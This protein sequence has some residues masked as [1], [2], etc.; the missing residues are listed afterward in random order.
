MTTFSYRGVTATGATVKGVVEAD[1]PKQ[2]RS[3]LLSD[4]IIVEYLAPTRVEQSHLLRR[5]LAVRERAGIFHGL[6]ELMKAGLAAGDAL[7]SLRSTIAGGRTRLRLELALDGIREGKGVARAL[8]EAGIVTSET[9]R[10][11]LEVGEQSGTLP[12]VLLRIAEFLE[13]EAQV[14]ERIATLSLYPSLVATLALLVALA[15]FGVVMPRFAALLAQAGIQ[16]PAG[17]VTALTVA[18]FVSLALAV[19]ALLGAVFTL[20]LARLPERVAQATQKAFFHI[21]GIGPLLRSLYTAR[22]AES[23]SLLLG[24]G[25]GAVDAVGI[26]ITSSGSRPAQARRAEAVATVEHG[27]SISKALA[28]LPGIEPSLANWLRMGEDSGRLAEMAARAAGAYLRDWNRAAERLI[29]VLEPVLVIA[30]GGLV[31]VVAISLL[32]P[33]LSLSRGLGL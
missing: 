16:L 25:M 21:P 2:A 30:V 28:G 29:T 6:A 24:A 22:L 14:K 20:L 15:M 9:E 10:A 23:L 18:K 31:L 8:H 27:G 7:Q 13:R 11:L 33:V 19:L 5:K 3:R 26:A 17:A 32:L 4:G 12:D 1:S